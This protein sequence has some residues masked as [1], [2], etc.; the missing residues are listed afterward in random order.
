MIGGAAWPLGEARLD[1]ANPRSLLVDLDEP[2]VGN[3]TGT[4]RGTADLRYDGEGGLATAD[5]NVVGAFWTSGVNRSTHELTT[6]WADEVGPDNALPEYPVRSSP[7]A[8]GATST[9]AGSSPPPR[10]ASSRRSAGR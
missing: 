1:P 10:P 4:A 6:R 7:G 9:G 3:R 2:V 8:S 5:G